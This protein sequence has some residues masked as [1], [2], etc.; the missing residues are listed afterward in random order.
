MSPKCSKRS[1]LRA[2]LEGAARV[3]GGTAEVRRRL[4]RENRNPAVTGT[5]GRSQPAAPASQQPAAVSSAA[6]ARPQTTGHAGSSPGRPS[7]QLGGE[8]RKGHRSQ[9]GR[10]DSRPGTE[11][12]PVTWQVPQAR[13]LLP[14]LGSS[15]PRSTQG[16]QQGRAVGPGAPQLVGLHCRICWG[17][18]SFRTAA[19]SPAL[20]RAGQFSLLSSPAGWTGDFLK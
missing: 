16:Q 5:R 14:S 8:L 6:A 12:A 17:A 19:A 13:T 4:S 1:A 15:R 20:P 11:R 3:R 2:I 9:G 10:R 7:R 18:K